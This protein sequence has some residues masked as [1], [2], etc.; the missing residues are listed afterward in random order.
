MA[1]TLSSYSGIPIRPKYSLPSPIMHWVSKNWTPTLYSKLI[2]TSKYFF[3]VEKTLLIN[4]FIAKLDSTNLQIAQTYDIE[5][6]T[7]D[8]EFISEKFMLNDY[9]KIDL[10]STKLWFTG[11]FFGLQGIPNFASKLLDY[12]SRFT[13]TTLTLCD[14]HLSFNEM[15]YISESQTIQ[16][17][18]LC[19]TSVVNDDDSLVSICEILTLIPKL[20]SFCLV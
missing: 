6:T 1:E 2:Q 11:E 3:Y 15:S 19:N 7:W 12:S 17:M 8:H 10:T 14:Q 4:D 20:T 5:K 9:L 13:I 18:E 16:K